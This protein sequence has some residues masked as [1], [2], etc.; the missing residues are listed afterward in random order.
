MKYQV[1]EIGTK[2]GSLGNSVTVPDAYSRRVDI[3]IRPGDK[4]EAADANRP[5]RTD[6]LLDRPPHWT[7]TGGEADRR[8]DPTET[9][10]D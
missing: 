3:F 2:F 10:D 1:S 9:Y 4:Y 7:P 8:H 5:L 6:E